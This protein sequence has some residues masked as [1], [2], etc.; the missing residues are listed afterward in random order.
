MFL[1]ES[2]VSIVVHPSW[3][4]CWWK[5]YIPWKY[6]EM[7][8]HWHSFTS[9]KTW[10]LCYFAYKFLLF[11]KRCWFL[12]LV[13]STVNELVLWLFTLYKPMIWITCRLC[14]WVSE[15][16]G[17]GTHMCAMLSRNQLLKSAIISVIIAEIFFLPAWCLHHWVEYKNSIRTAKKDSIVSPNLLYRDAAKFIS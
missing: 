14:V 9:R 2:D 13:F 6:Q 5:Y 17:D 10:T 15:C 3:S 7:L 16:D 1:Y 4:S 8:S 12:L 11:L